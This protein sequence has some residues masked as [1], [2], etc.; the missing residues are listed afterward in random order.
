MISLAVPNA[1]LPPPFPSARPQSSQPPPEERAPPLQVAQCRTGLEY[2]FFCAANSQIGGLFR[3]ASRGSVFP[4]PEKIGPASASG[5]PRFV[6]C[7]QRHG[8]CSPPRPWPLPAEGTVGVCSAGGGGTPAQP[9][10]RPRPPAA[11]LHLQP[12]R[13]PG[14]PP[15][16][17]GPPAAGGV[18][19]AV[20]PLGLPG[21]PVR[22]SPPSL[23]Q[24]G[25]ALMLNKAGALGGSYG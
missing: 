4:E 21:G 23:G 12:G 3:P 7:S 10:G 24:R 8:R 2:A 20:R 16:R 22:G 17:G 19:D 9:R 11:V 18:R 25:K 15:P 1:L 5:F 14:R 6:S 13:P